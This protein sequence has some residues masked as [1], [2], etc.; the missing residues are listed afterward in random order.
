MLRDQPEYA[1]I[2][3]WNIKDEIIPKL[4]AAGYKGEFIIPC[5]EP[6]VD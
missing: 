6:H 3:S 5:P 2:L 1:L 4:R